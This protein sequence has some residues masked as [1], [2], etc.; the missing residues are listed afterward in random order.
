MGNVYSGCVSGFY[1]WVEHWHKAWIIIIKWFKSFLS[2]MLLL[3][4]RV[5]SEPGV[6]YQCYHGF[7]RAVQEGNIQWESR[8]YPYPGTPITQ[9][10]SHS[11][12]IL[13]YHTEGQNQLLLMYI[14]LHGTSLCTAYHLV[15]NLT[16]IYFSVNW[17]TSLVYSGLNV[18]CLVQD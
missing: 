3:L 5:W 14:V 2:F 8:T 10:F 12:Y 17:R 16:D 18:F 13:F 4:T 1:T 11:Q 7:L 9:R 6:A 15:I